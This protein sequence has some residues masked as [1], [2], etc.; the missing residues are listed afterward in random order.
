MD[1]LN[2]HNQRIDS[3]DVVAVGNVVRK[4][5]K[6]VLCEDIFGSERFHQPDVQLASV[7]ELT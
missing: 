3:G 1:E 6:M 5:S 4:L 7:Y 2:I